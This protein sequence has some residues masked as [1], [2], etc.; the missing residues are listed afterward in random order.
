MIFFYGTGPITFS[1]ANYNTL[2]TEVTIPY[3][4]LIKNKRVSL[5]AVLP[6]K[7]GTG[8]LEG[9][10]TACDTG[11]PLENVN[12]VISTYSLITDSNGFY[13]V[14]LAKGDNHTLRAFYLGYPT[15]DQSGITVN[16]GQ[17]THLDFCMTYVDCGL[18]VY[19]GT[20][21]ITIA[22]EPSGHIVSPLRIFNGTGTYGV[23]LVNTTDPMAS[24]VRIQTDSGAQALRKL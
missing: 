24:P 15:Y 9:H 4:S 12:L 7:S 1:K 10:V 11:Q 5:N 3:D 6:A 13:H 8:V 21:I 2:S 18:R 22:C 17:T 23:A 19:N 14:R 16:Q 20:S